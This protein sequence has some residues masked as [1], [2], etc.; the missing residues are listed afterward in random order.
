M[1]QFSHILRFLRK[2]KKKKK[3]LPVLIYHKISI[4][5]KKQETH[6]QRTNKLDVQWVVSLKFDIHKFPYRVFV[7]SEYVRSTLLYVANEL[8]QNV[9]L[10][11]TYTFQRSINECLDDEPTQFGEN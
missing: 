1:V 9:D 2:S 10:M 3:E 7:H 5:K 6:Q 11:Y 4:N 8:L